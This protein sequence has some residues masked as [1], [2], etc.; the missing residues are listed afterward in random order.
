MVGIWKGDPFRMNIYDEI[1]S[2]YLRL[3]KGQRKVAQF[4]LEQPSTITANIA[5]EVGRLAGVSES[6]VIRF[7]YAID[8]SGYGELQDK[9]REYLAL[10]Q[11]I[12]SPRVEEKISSDEVKSIMIE[13]AKQISEAVQKMDSRQIGAA[14]QLL[15]EAKRIYIISDERLVPL[16]NSLKSGLDNAL[17]I[18]SLEQMNTAILNA[19]RED[20]FVL[21][22]DLNLEH[23]LDYLFDLIEEIGCN[24]IFVHDVKNHMFKKRCTVSLYLG[25]ELSMDTFATYSLLLSLNKLLK[26]DKVE[27]SQKIYA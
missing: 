2:K 27:A 6:T 19:E 16:A 15:N 12:N 11:A 26:A 3:S 24:C 4:I 18:S 7:C 25:Q 20:V 8:L 9:L 14:L 22:N 13:H 21:L 1:K 17:T 23:Q 10:Q 5:T